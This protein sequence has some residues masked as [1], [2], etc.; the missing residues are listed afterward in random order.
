MA[1]AH[2][3]SEMMGHAYEPESAEGA[4]KIPIFQ[5]ST[6]VFD[7][8]EQGKAFFE[9]AEGLRD[10]EPGERL[11][12]IYSR[13]DNPDLAVLEARLRLWDEAEAA[14]SFASTRSLDTRQ[15]KQV[16]VADV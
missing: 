12:M 6:F 7:T 1:K 9:L 8:A 10:P 5:T 2:P 15:S 13:L 11:G 14:V 4:L 16:D 3:A